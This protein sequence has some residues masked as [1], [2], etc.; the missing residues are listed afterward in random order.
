MSNDTTT[1]RGRPSFLTFASSSCPVIAPDSHR[2]VRVTSITSILNVQTRMAPAAGVEPADP[3][4]GDRTAPKRSPINWNRLADS[5]RPRCGH[6]AAPSPDR[7]SRHWSRPR[8]TIPAGG[9]YEQPLFPSERPLSG[10][11]GWI[12]TIDLG[13]QRARRLPLRHSPVLALR[14]GFDP[15][16]AL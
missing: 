10:R 1:P 2:Y 11:R 5:N 3:G 14:E 6:N 8:V 9:R 4:F 15:S 13:V 12:R 16:P 7:P